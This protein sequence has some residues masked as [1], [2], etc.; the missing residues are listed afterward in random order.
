MTAQSPVERRASRAKDPLLLSGRADLCCVRPE[1]MLLSAF[2][3]YIWLTEVPA[4]IPH[5]H[6]WQGDI[7][8]CHPHTPRE[9]CNCSLFHSQDDWVNRKGS[10]GKPCNVRSHPSPTVL[11]QVP[12]LGKSSL[13]LKFAD[14]G[15][16]LKIKQGIC[17]LFT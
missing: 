4:F 6:P 16:L 1:A 3:C 15:V 14:S 11:S 17:K 13:V 2:V 10:S 7:D 12:A 9:A 8:G 5:T